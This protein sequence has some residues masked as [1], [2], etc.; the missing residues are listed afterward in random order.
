MSFVS[1]LILLFLSLYSLEEDTSYSMILKYVRKN[2]VNQAYLNLPKR[3]S[4]NI[5]KMCNSINKEKESFSLND[6]ELTYLV[7]YWIAQNLQIDCLNYNSKYESALIAFNEGISS[8]KGISS[9]FSTMMTNL[10]ILNQI[11]EG[12]LRTPTENTKNGEIEEILEHIWSVVSIDGYYFLIDVMSG[13]GRCDGNSFSKDYTDF[14]FGTVP[15]YLIRSHFPD[16][17]KWQLLDSHISEK[18]FKSWP[19]L[20]KNFYLN[21]FDTIN[22]DIRTI[23]ISSDLQLTLTYDKSRNL[24]YVCKQVIYNGSS[25]TFITHYKCSLSNGIFKATFSGNE[26]MNY[27]VMYAGKREDDKLRSLV[28]YK[29]N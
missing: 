29:V 14:Y 20:G 4:T 18:K 27:F 5:L 22:P 7:Y 23:K 10:G 28:V 17:D 19:L 16:S 9:L 13:M 2:I 12:S 11:I 3:Q 26:E 1:L 15:E 8:Y 21:G 25:Y 24:D 6:Y